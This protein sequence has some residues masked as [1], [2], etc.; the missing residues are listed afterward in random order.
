MFQKR[1]N[2]LKKRILF[3]LHQTLWR[4]VYCKCFIVNNYFFLFFLGSKIVS[5]RVNFFL[6]LHFVS[7]S[8]RRFKHVFRSASRIS[9]FSVIHV[10][11]YLAP[12]KYIPV[13]AL[14]FHFI[15]CCMLLSFSDHTCLES[16]V[17]VLWAVFLLFKVPRCSVYLSLKVRP[18]IPI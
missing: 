11:Q 6:C 12:G 8:V 1:P 3:P 9:I 13:F 2:F 7:I 4:E 15:S 16:R 10:S 5:W 17:G 14:S 18:V